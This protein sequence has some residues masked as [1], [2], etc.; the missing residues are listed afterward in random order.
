MIHR[1]HP[2]SARHGATLVEVLMALLVMAVGV[3][4]VFTL[5]PLS[6]MRSIK[7][8]QLTNSKLVEE[9]ARE[10][11][12][13]NPQLVTGAPPWKPAS[14]YGRTP[15]T[16]AAGS[17]NVNNTPSDCWVTPRLKPGRLLPGTNLLYH[18]AYS[19]TPGTPVGYTSLSEPSWQRYDL[20]WLSDNVVWSPVSSLFVNAYGG[21]TQNLSGYTQ[22]K[23]IP[24]PIK[25]GGVTWTAYR[26]SL[27]PPDPTWSAY[28][29][30]PLGWYEM[31]DISPP[32]YRDNF[33]QLDRI[34]CQLTRVQANQNFSSQDTWS[35]V[36]DATLPVAINS[37]A[38][39]PNV[40]FEP[41]VDLSQ[42]RMPSLL[43]QPSN[44]LVFLT[45]DGRQS[46]TLDVD[47]SVAGRGLPNNQIGWVG[48][49]NLNPADISAVRVDAYESR[50]SW[51]MSVRMG[52][53]GL[54]RIDCVVFF[55]RS[56]NPL[57]E[58]A[59]VAE[60]QGTGAQLRWPQ[61]RAGGDLPL[62]AGG[63]VFDAAN[64]HWYRIQKVVS[65][66]DT[67]DPRVAVLALDGGVTTS[68]TAAIDY[69]GAA[70]VLPNII[71]VFH[72]DIE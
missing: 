57:D 63:F 16:T 37:G 62:K 14:G 68:T 66:D 53:R 49:L 65:Y 2:R 22:V 51:M 44:R 3:V 20:N 48:T 58:E 28:V 29:V 24:A 13:A 7:A 27:Y 10:V 35:P 6:I 43:N 61:S 4:S 47:T 42:S 45:E 31:E 30:D 34:H 8:N 52:P 11:I 39:I 12:L 25:D 69:D 15:V 33:G 18:S 40:E 41:Q 54:A 21:Y 5:F 64:G 17:V 71:N 1:P 19:G 59:V 38:S 72:M 70:I 50:Y 36:L 60:F 55:N 26:H 23:Y 32:S 46:Q 9:N 56:F 67:V